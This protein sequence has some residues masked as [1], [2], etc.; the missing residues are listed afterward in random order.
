MNIGKKYVPVVCL[1][2]FLIMFSACTSVHEPNAGFLRDYPS[3][4]KGR[5]FKQERVAGDADLTKYEKI[6]VSPVAIDRFQNPYK[7]YSD[8]EIQKILKAAFLRDM[9]FWG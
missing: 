8:A 5:D 1:F 2:A 4:Q 7:E 9:K 6:K 3:L